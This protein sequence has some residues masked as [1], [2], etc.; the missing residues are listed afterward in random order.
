VAPQPFEVKPSAPILLPDG[1][2]DE[3]MIEWGLVP[4]GT[5]A[6]IYLPETSAAQILKWA[7]KLYA[8]HRLTQV[9]AGTIRCQTGDVT[10][11]PVP[12]G[13]GAAFVGL[14]TI[15]LPP[16]IR[17]GQEFSVVVRQMT[18]AVYRQRGQGGVAIRARKIVRDAVAPV[19]ANGQEYLSW[20]RVAGIFRLT[21][22]VSTKQALLAGEEKLLS[23]MRW[24]LLATPAQSR[25][26][27]VLTRYVGQL[28]WRVDGMG[29][30]A[31]AVGPSGDGN[32]QRHSGAWLRW[33][34]WA[35]W[36][37]W[38]WRALRRLLAL[39]LG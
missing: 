29:G 13:K 20:R 39:A 31:G 25:W 18:S 17:R 30:N 21:I 5:T 6:T 3:L 15:E 4:S 35:A 7:D 37:R 38:W 32:W 26:H 16:G 8:T 28:A 10:Y 9:D 24:N 23:I 27:P 14:M 22:P 11:I 12:Q 34:W 2:P 1:K 36:W 19:P 33:W